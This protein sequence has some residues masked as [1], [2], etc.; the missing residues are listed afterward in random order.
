MDVWRAA[1]FPPKACVRLIL[2]V[3]ML[4]GYDFYGNESPAL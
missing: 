4:Q 2:F 1:R 3:L